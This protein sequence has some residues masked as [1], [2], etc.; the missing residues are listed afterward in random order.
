MK[1]DKFV[2]GEVVNSDGHIGSGINFEIVDLYPDGSM[3]IKIIEI[4]DDWDK[5]GVEV[6]KEYVLEYHHH[7]SNDEWWIFQD[8]KLPWFILSIDNGVKRFLH[9]R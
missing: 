1:T 8:R 2:V 6:G 4:K 9:Y 3:Q 7:S 5:E